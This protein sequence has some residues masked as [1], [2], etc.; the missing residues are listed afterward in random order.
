MLWD[1]RQSS[2]IPKRAGNGAQ[3]STLL[4]NNTFKSPLQSPLSSSLSL[5]TIH[6]GS[7]FLYGVHPSKL[8]ASGWTVVTRQPWRA[9]ESMLHKLSGLGNGRKLSV[10]V[11]VW[12]DWDSGWITLTADRGSPLLSPLPS[13]RLWTTDGTSL[14]AGSVDH[15]FD[16]EKLSGLDPP[17]TN[18]LELAERQHRIATPEILRSVDTPDGCTCCFFFPYAENNTFSHTGSRSDISHPHVF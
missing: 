3:N 13:S 5:I 6:T 11:L 9:S 10:C 17:Q 4:T 2:Y 1:V 14:G 18:K 15:H 16:R 8:K 12:T 7:P